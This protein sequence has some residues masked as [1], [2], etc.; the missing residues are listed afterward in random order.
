MISYTSVLFYLPSKVIIY[1][2][3]LSVAH[4]SC[5]TCGIKTRA[6]SQEP[7]AQD[8]TDNSGLNHAIS[9]AWHGL[10]VSA[11]HLTKNEKCEIFV[12]W[13]VVT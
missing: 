8:Q 13:S 11:S 3:W 6:V 10:H 5:A 12:L 2:L 7:S 1:L 4:K 9:R